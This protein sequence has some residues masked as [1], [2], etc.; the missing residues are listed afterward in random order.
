MVGGMTLQL[1]LGMGFLSVLGEERFI[2]LAEQKGY[3]EKTVHVLYMENDVVKLGS[4][5]LYSKK[6]FH[7]P[8]SRYKGD[9]IHKS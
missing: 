7:L 2:A 9:A 3:Q 8:F 1:N 6:N 4:S 5:N